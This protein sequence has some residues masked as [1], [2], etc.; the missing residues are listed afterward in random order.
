VLHEQ[1]PLLDFNRFVGKLSRNSAGYAA[2]YVI[3][4]AERDD[5]LLQVSSADKSKLYLNGREVYKNL[6]GGHLVVLDRVNPVTLHKG[7]NVL[8]LKVVSWNWD[9]KGCV[10]FLDRESNPATGL[11][12]SLTPE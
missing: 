12:V 4:A 11:Q 8:V 5:L 9:W 6:Q 2:C 7:T 1:G 3:S 10:R